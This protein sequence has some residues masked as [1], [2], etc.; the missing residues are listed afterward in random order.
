MNHGNSCLKGFRVPKQYK[1]CV[2]KP[3]RESEEDG[4]SDK[5]K[6][7]SGWWRD[8]EQESINKSL[9]FKYLFSIGYRKFLSINLY[10]FH[11]WAIYTKKEDAKA[12]RGAGRNLGDQIDYA[13]RQMRGQ[14]NG[15][16][17]FCPMDFIAE[18]VLVMLMSCLAETRKPE[19]Q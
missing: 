10:P 18:I 2:C 13:L 12:A 8:V 14:T 19:Y 4:V 1:N 7:V 9:Q 3:P 6:A 15:I 5:A 11:T 16:P 17:R